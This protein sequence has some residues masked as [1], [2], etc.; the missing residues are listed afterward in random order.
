[1]FIC[2]MFH[3]LK[4]IFKVEPIN[5]MHICVCIVTLFFISWYTRSANQWIL[6]YI[7]RPWLMILLLLN[8]TKQFEFKFLL[9]LEFL[10]YLRFRLNYFFNVFM[11]STNPCFQLFHLLTKHRMFFHFKLMSIRQV[12]IH[13][14]CIGGWWLEG[15][16][17]TSTV[18][19]LL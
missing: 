18:N 11:A 7:I 17:D 5:V 12:L 4:I 6:W 1:M 19:L 16:I 8:F 14:R 2:A 10:L 15:L 9:S 3:Y 13:C